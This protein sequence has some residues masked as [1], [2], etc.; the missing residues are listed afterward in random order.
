MIQVR[1]IDELTARLNAYQKQVSDPKVKTRIMAAGG[2]VI[3][4]ATATSPTP[5]SKKDHWYYPTKG[6]A[7]VKVFSGNLRK[8]MKVFR[9][10]DGDVYIGPQVLKRVT[11]DI[12]KTAKTASGYYAATIFKSA[13]NFRREVTERAAS[14]TMTKVLA[15]VQKAYAK[16]HDQNAPK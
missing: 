1:G 6:G 12:G 16:F 8:S 10:K 13:A 7:R 3:K 14:L 15:A 11:G 9:G 2:Q 4:K 5:K